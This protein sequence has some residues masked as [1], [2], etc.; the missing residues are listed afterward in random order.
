M[1]RNISK[2]AYVR[3]PKTDLWHF[4]K[5]IREYNYTDTRIISYHKVS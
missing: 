2:L 1:Q 3:I 5:F 4:E